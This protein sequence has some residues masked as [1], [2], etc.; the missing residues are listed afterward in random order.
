MAY[1]WL[2]CYLLKETYEKVNFLAGQG[3]DAFTVKNESQI[4]YAKTLSIVYA[5]VISICFNN[6]KFRVN[7]MLF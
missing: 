5:E 6:N 1:K 7:V 2:I 3:I 4:F